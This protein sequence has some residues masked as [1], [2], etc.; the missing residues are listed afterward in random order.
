MMR[1]CIDN[2]SESSTCTDSQTIYGTNIAWN[3]VAPY[4]EYYTFILQAIIHN[5]AMVIVVTL[6]YGLLRLVL[7]EC[8]TKVGT[9]Y[10]WFAREKKSMNE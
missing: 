4:V 6:S 9:G 10:A 2:S 1:Y 3:T 5:V 8:V 7:C